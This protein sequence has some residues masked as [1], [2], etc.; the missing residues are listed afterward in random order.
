VKFLLALLLAFATSTVFLPQAWP[1]QTFQIGAFLLLAA[2]IVARPLPPFRWVWLPILCIPLWGLLQL[3]THSTAATSETRAAVLRWGALAAVFLLSYI[4]GSHKIAR[5]VFLDLFVGF[6]AALA[7]LCLT[8]LFTSHG[9]VLWLFDTGHEEV[10]GTFPYYNNY[11]Q[12]VE[13]ALPVALWSALSS[14]RGAIGYALAGGVLYASVIASTSRAGTLIC[15]FELL[16][17]LGIGLARLRDPDT[18][19]P[20]RR[21][22]AMLAAVPVLAVVLT[23]A[24]G[25]ER[26]WERFEQR[27]P[28][29]IRREFLVAAV[30]MAR[31][32][33]IIGF[34]LGTFPAVYQRYAIRDFP[35]YA[36]HAHDD[37]AEFAADGGIPFLLL[38]IVPFVFAVPAAI[39][40][41]W[42]LGLIGVM[43]HACVDY[44]FPRPAV[45]GW[46]FALLGM[47]YASTSKSHISVRDNAGLF[48]LH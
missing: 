14:G 34:G 3:V 1:L 18:G 16:A 37:W 12:F 7:V 17:I 47:L 39:R 20:S 15:T 28:Y 10:Y 48:D 6:A 45:S 43:L 30:D 13:L 19:S 22:A 35:F 27:D 11:A 5:R 40:H 29:V 2:C 46:I 42:A 9:S 26:V 4:L 31:Q 33:P 21:T 23:L 8:Q 32:R 41:P 44:P 24:V 36:N 25:W 38:I